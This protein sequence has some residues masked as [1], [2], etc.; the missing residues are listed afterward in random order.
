MLFVLVSHIHVDKCTIQFVET[1][2]QLQDETH[3]VSNS[4]MISERH[5]I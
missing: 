3:L 5:E 2:Y 1:L 4:T